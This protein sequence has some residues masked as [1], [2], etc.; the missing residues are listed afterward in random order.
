MEEISVCAPS[1]NEWAVGHMN[2]PGVN[3]ARRPPKRGK[4][5]EG[6]NYL[7]KRVKS[8]YLFACVDTSLD[9]KIGVEQAFG[10]HTNITGRPK[11][12]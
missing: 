3:T 5:T 2:W 11:F 4:S 1:E 7:R 12:G 8:T 9:S 6:V 10:V